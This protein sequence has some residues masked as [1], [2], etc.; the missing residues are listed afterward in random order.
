MSDEIADLTYFVEVAN[1]ILKPEAAIS[2]IDQ[3][4]QK[5]ACFDKSECD[6]FSSVFKNSID[7]IRQ[8]LRSLMVSY[9]NEVDEG[10]ALKADMIQ[11]YKEKSHNQLTSLCNHALDLIQKTLL[12]AAKTVAGKAFFHKTCADYYRYL[13]EFCRTD[14]KQQILDKTEQEYSAA[15]NICR[16]NLLPC[17]PVR[18]G[19]ILNYGIFKC[20]HLGNKEE[21][22]ELLLSA[23][24]D[25]ELDFA[26]MSQNSQAETL[27]I[28]H[29]LRANLA[30][31]G[32]DEDN[33]NNQ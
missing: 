8:T 7:P 27:E 13:A 20:E 2:F 32:E 33:Q 4:V 28:L 14:E 5:K 16:A 23:I 19:V 3:L 31:W 11:K 26:Q 9:N 17:D 10:H 22:T 6:L 12:P 24:R 1:R 25:A 29:T 21:A 30:A 18:L 15:L